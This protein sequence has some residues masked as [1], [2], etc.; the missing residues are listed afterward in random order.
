MGARGLHIVDISTIGSSRTR[1]G[2]AAAGGGGG[3][4]IPVHC[5]SKAGAEN[6][7][8]V[9]RGGCVVRLAHAVP[10]QAPC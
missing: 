3:L 1:G 2:G 6:R 9:K 8:D 7:V 5:A 4:L 10:T